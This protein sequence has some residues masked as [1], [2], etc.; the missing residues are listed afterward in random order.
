MI[1]FFFCI[2]LRRPKNSVNPHFHSVFLSLSISLYLCFVPLSTSS[3]ILTI[4]LLKTVDR[5]TLTIMMCSHSQFV[6]TQ[7]ISK[8]TL[9]RLLCFI[10]VY[11]FHLIVFFH[12]TF[13]H[14]NEMRWCQFQV[15]KRH[16]SYSH[17]VAS[18]FF[19]C[20]LYFHNMYEW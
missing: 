4:F 11:K 14:L 2:L 13:Y 5:M 1:K 3:S 18:V 19:L 15:F 16:I 10:D 7:L 20:C 6:C 12:F 8:V 17:R 9:G